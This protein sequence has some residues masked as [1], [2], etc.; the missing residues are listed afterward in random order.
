MKKGELVALYRNLNQLGNLN[1]VK[2]SYAVAKN[3]NIIKPEIEA[4]EKSME[5]PDKYKE[6]D[7]A[8]VALVEK[9]AVKDENGKPKKEK[10]DNGA[11]QYVLPTGPEEKKFNKEFEALKKEHKE[12]VDL[13]DKQ[14][15]EYT[16]MLTEESTVAL[17]KVKLE[18]VPEAI[19]TRQMAGIAEIIEE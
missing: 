10:A 13:R 14:V 3:L 4:L 16:K 17:Y 12:A 19:T 1:G 8:R 6:F 18:F 11:E 2:F 15:E 9:Y 5:L 7:N